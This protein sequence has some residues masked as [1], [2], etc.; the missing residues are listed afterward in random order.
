MDVLLPYSLF[1][2]R[3]PWPF[4]AFVSAGCLTGT[5]ITRREVFHQRTSNSTA[6]IMSCLQLAPALPELPPFCVLVWPS[7]PAPS[8][9]HPLRP[10][11]SRGAAAAPQRAPGRAASDH[12]C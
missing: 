4:D 11:R 9:P 3:G 6:A 5:K 2:V 10:R 7:L 8:H 12:R 1:G